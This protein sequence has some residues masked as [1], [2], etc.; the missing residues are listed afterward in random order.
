MRLA[1]ARCRSRIPLRERELPPSAD[2][3]VISLVSANDALHQRVADDIDVFKLPGQETEFVKVPAH[4]LA[5][6]LGRAEC[7]AA[8]T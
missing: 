1:L 7:K 3:L 8:T 4:V 2:L 6:L 5:Y